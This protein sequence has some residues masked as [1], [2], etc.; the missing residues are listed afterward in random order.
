[1]DT[2][3]I[4]KHLRHIS[5]TAITGEFDSLLL[6]Q[7]ISFY[8][9]VFKNRTGSL[10]IFDII[11]EL[12]RMLSLCISQENNNPSHEDLNKMNA[13]LNV[14]SEKAS[15]SD[16]LKVLSKFDM[17][18]I[19][20]S[21]KISAIHTMLTCGA[22]DNVE[23][24]VSGT[25]LRIQRVREDM[26]RLDFGEG[27]SVYNFD[28]IDDGRDEEDAEGFIWPSILDGRMLISK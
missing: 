13:C 1:M 21:F 24:E 2:P 15:P 12:T 18:N 9:N 3:N 11:T 16:G 10:D 4:L 25:L 26:Q 28:E 20:L 17:S 7:V 5:E 23:N 8:T 6:G 27:A 14:I 22:H 19:E